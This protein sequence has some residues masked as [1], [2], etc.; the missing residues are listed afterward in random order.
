MKNETPDNL[1]II[2]QEPQEEGEDKQRAV[3]E[4]QDEMAAGA[5]K[6]V[7]VRVWQQ[8]EE[9]NKTEGSER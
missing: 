2:E 6:M 9:G 4:T 7:D 3:K 5:D 1:S 8:G